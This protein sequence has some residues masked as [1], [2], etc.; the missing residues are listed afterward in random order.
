MKCFFSHINSVHKS[1]LPRV[2][3]ASQKPEIPRIEASQGP[4]PL[5]SHVP[6]VSIAQIPYSI[7]SMVNTSSS[8]TSN[9]AP[10][11]AASNIIS[12][13]AACVANLTSSGAN[14]VMNLVNNTLPVGLP[15][16]VQHVQQQ[17][18]AMMEQQ[19]SILGNLQNPNMQVT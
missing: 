18:Q 11:S 16:M 10:S 4:P 9:I 13:S 12:N 1:E 5:V 19:Q 17:H 3:A 8:A 2:E 7:P 14:S 15:M 6:Q